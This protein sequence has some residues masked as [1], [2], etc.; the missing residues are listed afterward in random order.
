MLL[1]FGTVILL[2][3]TPATAGGPG[4]ALHGPS[5]WRF[6]GVACEVMG[7]MKTQEVEQY[8]KYLRMAAD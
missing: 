3:G 7:A 5:G 4:S 8:G 2:G 6:G 1:L